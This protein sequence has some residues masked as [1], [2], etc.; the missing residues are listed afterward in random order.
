MILTK[1]QSK[2]LTD[3]LKDLN[4]RC[5]KGEVVRPY[6]SRFTCGFA[7]INFELYFEG[8]AIAKGHYS[9]IRNYIENT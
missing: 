9:E 6:L 5:I 4:D 7:E 2:L 3:L 1:K 8:E